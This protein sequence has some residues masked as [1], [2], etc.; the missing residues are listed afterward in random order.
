MADLVKYVFKIE[1]K[2]TIGTLPMERLAQYMADLSKMLGEPERVHFIELRESSVGLVHVVEPDVLTVI[3]E[4]LNAV[5]RGIADV[6]YMA[7]YRALDKKLRIDESSATYSAER[8]PA[9][10]L[11]FP[12]R[13]GPEPV[14]YSGI[15]QLGSI[16]GAIIRLGGMRDE[17]P[18]TVLEGGA[19]QR[20]CVASKPLA[21]ELAKHLFE[22][23]LRLY[24]TGKWARDEDGIWTLQR[25]QITNFEPLDARPLSAVLNEL[26]S[27]PV[28]W[29]S[30]DL[31]REA[32]DQR[33][34]IH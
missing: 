29:E 8:G 23:E 26:R 33:G 4:R 12:G 27:L 22:G 3:D 28:D 17:I 25:F 16:D 15:P 11:T 21:K 5:E 1:G 18:V 32:K 13:L 9:T 31:W 6:T 14:V 2:Y 30:E 34:N 10:V 20:K 19:L 7:A 24:G